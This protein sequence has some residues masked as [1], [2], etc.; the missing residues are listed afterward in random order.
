MHIDAIDQGSGESVAIAG[1]LLDRAAHRPPISP[2]YPQ[3]QGFMARDQL[4]PCGEFAGALEPREIHHAALP[5]ARAA[6]RAHCARTRE[7]VQKQ[8]S[9][10]ANEVAGFI[11]R[12]RSAP[13]PRPCAADCETAG[14]RRDWVGAPRR[15]LRSRLRGT[16]G[17]SAAAVAPAIVARAMSC[18]HRRTDHQQPVFTGR[19]NFQSALAAN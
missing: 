6:P 10:C 7:L 18:R 16:R 13:Q 3:G 15:I 8:Y 17:P 2:A 5:A 14:V 12:R 9:Q 4:K 11:A 1:D 19:R